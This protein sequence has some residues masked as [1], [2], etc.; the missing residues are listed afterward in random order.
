[1]KKYLNKNIFEGELALPE[2]LQLQ[3][4]QLWRRKLRVP[5]LKRRPGFVSCCFGFCFWFLVSCNQFSFLSVFFAFG[6]LDCLKL[7]RRKLMIPMLLRQPGF[8]SCQFFLLLV[9]L[10]VSSEGALYVILPYD[11]PAQRPKALNRYPKFDII[12]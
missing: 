9:Y 2:A 12:R 3:L 10:F 8:V 6:F 4:F 5:M 7:L 11:Y 1:M